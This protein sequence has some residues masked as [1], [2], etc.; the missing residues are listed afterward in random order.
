MTE[1]KSAEQIA[2]MARAGF[3]LA[4]CREALKTYVKPGLSTLDIDGFVERFLA[5]RGATPEQKG[6]SG[7]PYATCASVNDVACHGMPG[8][9]RLRDGDIVTIDM[10]VNREGWLADSA[11]TF[12]VGRISASSRRLMRTAKTCLFAGVA[13]AI[14]GNRTGDIAHAIQSIASAKGY[15]VL[16]DFTG[17]GI[18]TSIHEWPTVKHTG[19]PGKGGRLEEGM[20][21]TIEPILTAG[22]PKVKIESDG[23]TARAVDGKRSAQYEHTVAVT[24]D[25]PLILTALAPRL[26]K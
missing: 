23:W 16:S 25:G 5:E 19:K 17:H 12:A 11:W 18:G 6:Y 20:V 24:R 3:I 15:K 9:E 4:S 7:Y 14:P 21:I 1:W 8:P 10:V 22:K 26:Y 13:Q 2:R